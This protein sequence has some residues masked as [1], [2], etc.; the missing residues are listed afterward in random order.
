MAIL[1]CR[2]ASRLCPWV[3]VFTGGIA[4]ANEPGNYNRLQAMRQQRQCIG[5]VLPGVPEGRHNVANPDMVGVG[6]LCEITT[7]PGRGGTK[8]ELQTR[9]RMYR[10]AL[11]VA[12]PGL[13]LHSHGIPTPTGSGWATLFRAYGTL[14]KT[15]LGHH[16]PRGIYGSGIVASAGV[17]GRLSCPLEFTEVTA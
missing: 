9:L 10:A 8:H 3:Q 2:T 7:N 1:P 17:E 14:R 5:S 4:S 15:K 16:Q 6:D 12:P 11:C 13:A